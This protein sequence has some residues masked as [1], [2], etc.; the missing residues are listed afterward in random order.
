M[1]YGL[2][3]LI[4]VLVTIIS[5][6]VSKKSIICL[7]AASVIGAVFLYGGR[8]P[9]GWLQ[10]ALDVLTGSLSVWA[11][12][13]MFGIIIALLEKSG[14]ILGFST[15]VRGI[16]NN[17]N[18][19]LLTAYGLGFVLMVDNYLS[20]I[21]RGAAMKQLAKKQQISG[22][23]L[24]YVIDA[25]AATVSALF[26]FS[27]WGTFFAV[28]MMDQVCFK[29][30]YA[31]GYQAYA[32]V[33]PYLFY[34]F[35]CLLITLLF[36][37]GK[38]PVFPG[39][40]AACPID[41]GIGDGVKS[42]E[43]ATGDGVSSDKADG[44]RRSG[45][46]GFFL[47]ILALVILTI[48][49]GEILIGLGVSILLCAVLYLPK[50]ILTVKEFLLDSLN[51]IAGM[52][53]VFLTLFASYILRRIVADM[54]ITDFLAGSALMSVSGVLL[55][56]VT[57]TVVSFLSFAIGSGWGIAPLMAAIFIPLAEV[58][59]A[60]CMPVMGAIISGTV[61][62]SH[63]CFFG[64]DTV[65]SAAS[66]GVDTQQHAVSQFPYAII[67]FIV[68]FLLYLLPGLMR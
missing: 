15:L 48:V 56:P 43:C 55:A 23:E 39:M 20:I 49:T 63:A 60:D 37:F 22:N 16:C 14:A 30:S 27:S 42:N 52:K 4:L 40:R 62:C 61:F 21:A 51:G 44:R 67:A 58:T 25:S 10:L 18:H 41:G 2:I 35:V 36:C 64:A 32:G 11:M 31:S 13:V 65:L 3:A 17:R 24:S 1:N 46:P 59:G 57:F 8:F 12:I 54:G 33:I 34:P 26:P 19:T 28:I 29:A 6:V 9:I 5:A 66:C 53:T 45:L 50:K 7:F 68:S 38:F 47:P